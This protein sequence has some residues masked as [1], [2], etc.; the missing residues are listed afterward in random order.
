MRILLT[1]N[2]L[3][4]RAGTELYVRDVAL[5]LLARGHEPIAYSRRLG[6]VAEELRRRT[7]PVVDDLTALGRPPELIHAQ[8]HL[9]A[10]TALA[11]FPGVPAVYV[12]HGW[13]PPE[14]A[15]PRHPR[16]RRYLAVDHLVR[17]RLDD[18]CGIPP[19][20]IETHLNFVDLERFT[21]RSPLPEIPARALVLSNQAREDTYLPAVRQACEAQGLSLDVAGRGVGRSIG[22]P[23]EILR[24]YDVVFAKGR[25]ALEA[26]TVGCAVV[27]C[28]AAGLGPLVTP[29]SLERLR[30]FNFGVRLLERS[31]TADAVAQRLG[32]Y[33][34][35][36]AAEVSRRLRT[37]IGLDA[38]VERLIDL[39]ADV[40]ANPR[41]RSTGAM[42]AGAAM[43][44]EDLVED[45]DAVAHYLRHGP[46][47][48]GDVFEAERQR[49][50]DEISRTGQWAQDLSSRLAA[51]DSTRRTLEG[52]LE[53]ALEA[54]H[55]SRGLAEERQQQVLAHRREIDRLVEHTAELNRQIDDLTGQVEAAAKKLE[56]SST[57][58]E[59][60]AGRLTESQH[61]VQTLRDEL[62]WMQR[63]STWTWRRRFL[64]LLGQG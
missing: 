60:V 57:E 61:E 16:I 55:G 38:A 49:L 15:P 44:A 37:E 19:A 6:E 9:E 12:C 10:M 34:A 46:L 52:R 56:A 45:L 50:R 53:Q 8:H 3:D 63:S 13:L 39:Y 23:E 29:G 27:L 24:E 18:E 48:G 11:H 22:K 62:E 31:V 1:N 20:Q 33:R 35:G 5:A 21:P 54:L 30:A 28:D 47:T 17:Q 4:Q 40:L 59:E 43:V 36:D 2:T 42:D 25:A 51:G 7:V 32:Q 58:F 26:A 14:E 41:D 64:R